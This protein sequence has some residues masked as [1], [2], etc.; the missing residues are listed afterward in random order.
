MSRRR[1]FTRI[2]VSYLIIFLLPLFINIFTLKD[3]AEET[4]K[5][6]CESVYVNLK[7]AQES[8]D[9]DIKEIDNIVANLTSNNNIHYLATQ[10]TEASKNVEFSK[11]KQAQEYIA[12]LQVQ[13][14]VDE[15]YVFF[16]KPQMIVSPKSVFLNQDSSRYFFTYNNMDLETCLA[17]RK[18]NRNQNFFPEALTMQN[19]KKQEMFLYIQSLLTAT[20]SKGVFVFPI[21]SEIIKSKLRDFYISNAGWAYIID[22]EDRLIISVPSNQN[23]FLRVDTKLPATETGINEIVV[24]GRILEVICTESEYTGLRYVAVIPQEYIAGEIGYAQ[25]KLVLLMAGVLLAGIIGICAVSWYKGKKITGIMQ[26]FFTVGTGGDAIPAREDAMEYISKSVKKLIDNNRDLRENILR[27]EPVTRS[28]LLER[29]MMGGMSGDKMR[30][31]L[32]NYGIGLDDGS[33]LLVFLFSLKE[34]ITADMD[35]EAEE[36]TIYKQLLN[37]DLESTFNEKKYICNIDVDSLAMILVLNQ[38]YDDKKE[39]NDS[40]LKGILKKYREEY[41][42]YLRIAVSSACTDWND[43]SRAYDQVCEIMDYGADLE[44]GILFYDEYQDKREYYYFPVTLEERLIN[45]VKTGNLGTIHEQLHQ[46]YTMNVLER[47]LSPAMMHSLINDLQC[48]IYKIMHSL[49][50][51]IQIDE[52]RLSRELEDLSKEKDL[53]NRFQHINQIFKM[54]GEKVAETNQEDK[55]QIVLDIALYVENNYQDQEMS[56]GKIAEAFGYANTYFSRLFKALFDVNFTTYLEKVR[57]THVCD[58][59]QTDMTL[60]KIAGM[61]GYNSVHVLRTAFKRMKG[62]TPNDYR[63]SSKEENL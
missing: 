40:K 62:M 21:R 2:I 10:M 17:Q 28:L 55:K 11:I 63:N 39:E 53:L 42:V 7:H 51:H 26:M 32:R 4:Q 16:D 48:T 29:L 5:N 18:N 25:R 37:N 19:V 6:I 13:T 31:S 43:V 60:E 23:E 58:L 38:Q 9:D 33:C 35:I 1:V 57:I 50:K 56:L 44:K 24:D 52:I 22:D 49:D 34:P 12:A 36:S 59:L 15:Y 27:Q 14:L 30:Q 46:I 47:S 8:V 45:A 41:G 20:G 3:I 54:L 61:T